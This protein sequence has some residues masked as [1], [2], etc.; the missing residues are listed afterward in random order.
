[1]SQKKP[2]LKCPDN[3]HTITSFVE[4]P[5]PCDLHERTK[6]LIESRKQESVRLRRCPTVVALGVP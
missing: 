3:Q 5:K 6:K 4:T 1:M 2:L